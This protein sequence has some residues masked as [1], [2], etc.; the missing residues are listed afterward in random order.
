MNSTNENK[1]TKLLECV[2]ITKHL[3]TDGNEDVLLV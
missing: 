1:E 3:V 2:E